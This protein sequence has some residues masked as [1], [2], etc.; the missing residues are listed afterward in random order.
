[1]EFPHFPILSSLLVIRA[2][3]KTM[4]AVSLKFARIPKQ[5]IR[6]PGIASALGN[7]IKPTL[8]GSQQYSVAVGSTIPQQKT[9]AMTSF[10]S[11]WLV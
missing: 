4:E 10:S 11:M 3:N 6:T 7:G 2:Y 8:N 9:H 1:M 5:L